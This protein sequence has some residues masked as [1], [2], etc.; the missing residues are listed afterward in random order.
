MDDFF[1]QIITTVPTSLI[2]KR[3]CAWRKKKAE[4]E[5]EEEEEEVEEVDGM[6]GRRGQI[7]WIR[8]LA[9]LQTQVRACPVCHRTSLSAYIYSSVV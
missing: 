7:L 3:L 2:P 8:G 6:P 4:E 9:R 1:A 5:A